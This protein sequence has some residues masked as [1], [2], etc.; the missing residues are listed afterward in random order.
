M[1]ESDKK[2]VKI[3]IGVCVGAMIIAI[4]G[5]II[6]YFSYSESITKN[7]YTDKLLPNTVDHLKVKQHLV[8]DGDTHVANSVV[9]ENS[10]F[11]HPNFSTAK[12]D[13]GTKGIQMSSVLL[14]DKLLV[15][16]WNSSFDYVNLIAGNITDVISNQQPL[17]GIQMFD[18]ASKLQNYKV[19][20]GNDKLFKT[21]KST[22]G[23]YSIITF[24]PGVWRINVNYYIDGRSTNVRVEE[25]LL[26]N[27]KNLSS[28]NSLEQEVKDYVFL[29]RIGHVPGP[30][31]NGERTLSSVSR[32]PIDNGS[33]IKEPI[34][35]LSVAIRYIL[36]SNTAQ[37]STNITNLRISCIK[38][39]D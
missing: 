27:N 39:G 32:F 21:Q 15:D 12:I 19:T 26:A 14:Q 1:I 2:I 30:I 5:V 17:P 7:T 36:P 33:T 24:T 3:I 6:S 35:T 13:V 8:V 37:T 18:F 25:I 28:L 23:N 29:D 22:N 16:I 20:S 9:I 31:F 10:N 4:A 34:N 38:L 11:S